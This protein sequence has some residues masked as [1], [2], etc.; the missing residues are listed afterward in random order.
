[1][2]YAESVECWGG[3]GCLANLT[4]KHETI[5][6]T[7]RSPRKV[8]VGAN[9]IADEGDGDKDARRRRHGQR[10]A[11]HWHRTHILRDGA[12]NEGVGHPSEY[13]KKQK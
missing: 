3:C 6:S 2:A 1:M 7:E 10:Q 11:D 4:K 12:S 8:Y 5:I 9:R 13:R